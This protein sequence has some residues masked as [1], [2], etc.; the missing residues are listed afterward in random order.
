[1]ARA[2]RDE[3]QISPWPFAG[4][5]LMASA[6]FLYA[7][8]GLV[9]PWWAVVVLMS[10]WT[11]LFVLCCRWWTPYP[12]RL[13]SVALGSMALWFVFLVLGAALLGW[14]E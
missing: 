8:S 9:A 3:G 12:K 10:V 14:G 13:V 7:A 11:A 6:F 5:V 1:M 2:P 4:M